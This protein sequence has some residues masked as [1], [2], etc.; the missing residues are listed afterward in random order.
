MLDVMTWYPELFCFSLI[1]L[2]L[3]SA[4]YWLKRHQHQ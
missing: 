1:V 2:L 3:L 4:V